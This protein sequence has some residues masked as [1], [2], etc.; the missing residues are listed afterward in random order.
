VFLIDDARLFDASKGDRLSSTYSACVCEYDA[1]RG[2]VCLARSERIVEREGIRGRGEERAF[3]CVCECDARRGRACVARSVRL[4]EC[5]ARRGRVC[6][7]VCGEECA[8]R[9]KGGD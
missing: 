2:R 8:N 9:G 3:A 1:R 6:V 4:C 5:D 7:C